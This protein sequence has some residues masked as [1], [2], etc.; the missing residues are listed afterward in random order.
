MDKTEYT[1]KLRSG[2]LKYPEEF[3]NNVMESFEEYFAQGLVRGKRSAVI[4]EE[5]GEP[6]A[7]LKKID[8]LYGRNPGRKE[9][10]NV[11][12]SKNR[13]L[14]RNITDYKMGASI[15]IP[16]LFVLGI[17]LHYLGII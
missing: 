6:E 14:M 3:R 11:W 13:E 4:L 12:V 5:L 7:L 17:I 16:L 8:E 10:D 9:I 15:L 1:F 2:L